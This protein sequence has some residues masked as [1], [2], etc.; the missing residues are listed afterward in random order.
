MEKKKNRAHDVFCVI[1]Y[2]IAIAFLLANLISCGAAKPTVVVKDSVRVE[3]HERIVHDTAYFALQPSEQVV[4]IKD[5]VSHLENAYA[6]TDAAIRGGL[7]F[8]SLVSTPKTITIPVTTIV[9]DTLR[10]EAKEN[11]IYVDV[12]RQASK[13]ESFLEICGYILLGAL[14]ILFA[15]IVLKL[16]FR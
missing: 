7:L 6:Q 10:I 2:I 11:T 14:F 1:V 13:W 3:I 9:H 16:F 12:P 8:H 4:M 5:T 15:F